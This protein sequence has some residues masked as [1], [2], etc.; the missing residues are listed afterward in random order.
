MPG[1]TSEKNLIT[2]I[3]LYVWD[4]KHVNAVS[5]FLLALPSII[6]DLDYCITVLEPILPP[7]LLFTSPPPIT[8]PRFYS[9]NTHILSLE[10]LQMLFKVLSMNKNYL[11]KAVCK[12]FSAHVLHLTP[13][14]S[15][16]LWGDI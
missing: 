1:G 15:L 13:G 14:L 6:T 12:L 10:I 11:N 16:S 3:H 2:I 9:P 4:A 7:T 8:H 5:S